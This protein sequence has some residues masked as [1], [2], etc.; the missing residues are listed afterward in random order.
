MALILPLGLAVSGPASSAAEPPA[1]DT[2]TP[3]DAP[4][5]GR[6]EPQEPLAEVG[7]LSPRQRE[8][9]ALDF[10][11]AGAP[12]P[13]G[14]FTL[15]AGSDL[16]GR[17][18]DLT[19]ALPRQGVQNLLAQANRPL[20]E[21]GA[22]ADPFGSGDPTSPTDPTPKPPLDPDTVR[23][24]DEG[25]SLGQEW[26]P[27]G[28]T[29]VSDAQQDEAWGTATGTLLTGWY[30]NDNPGRDAAGNCSASTSGLCFE[31]GVR[32]TFA[33][34]AAGTYRHV[35]LVWPYYAGDG[36]ITYQPIHSAGGQTGIHAGGMVWYG[37]Y[38]YVADTYNGIRV[39]D[40]RYLFDLNPDQDAATDD[41]TPDGLSS[42]VQ[43]GRRVGRQGGVWYGHGYRYVMPQVATWRY[44][45]T[46]Y[47]DGTG[48]VDVGAPKASYLSLDRSG[49]DH[50]VVGEYCSTTAAQPSTGRV[51]AWPIAE[52][53]R[54]S[55][56]VPATAG[57]P[58]FLPVHQAQGVARY[59]GRYYV[60]QSHRYSNGSLWRAT[61]T[62]G[63]LALEGGE[64]RTAVG[65]EDFYLEHGATT[66]NPPR[67]WSV[68]EHR[69]DTD[70][71][72]CRNSTPCGRVLYAHRLDAIRGQP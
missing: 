69:A 71:P 50:L 33:D 27:Q 44:T 65:P 64:I 29:G 38:L 55:G 18:A 62:G 36:R 66:G 21:D 2:P 26:I 72:S 1:A 70:D 53:E 49:V 61:V 22:C 3:G 16:S 57:S 68:S 48:C 5:D 19:A 25:D 34:P 15:T 56:T 63:R 31:K 23:C 7:T 8:L 54:R 47:N 52:L 28:L 40:M 32:V 60:N 42:D 43:D 14:E 30:D 17:I 20:G 10:P 51:G 9:A 12:A 37:N 45:A 24:F 13:A 11:G 67:L 6:W 39:F 35:L 58:Y 4:G 46:Q 41:R 59:E